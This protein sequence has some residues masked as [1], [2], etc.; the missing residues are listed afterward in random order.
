MVSDIENHCFAPFLFDFSINKSANS[1]HEEKHLKSTCDLRYHDIFIEFRLI[2]FT[3]SYLARYNG[4]NIICSCFSSI[5]SNSRRYLFEVVSI[6][7]D[8]NSIKM[9]TKTR[10]V[11]SIRLIECGLKEMT[12]CI[13]NALRS[14]INNFKQHVHV[15]IDFGWFQF[16]TRTD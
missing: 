7:Y 8:L 15:H 4:E 5:N 14:V 16:W 6:F 11:I 12:V 9:R 3:Y 2:I 13:P 1:W 10:C